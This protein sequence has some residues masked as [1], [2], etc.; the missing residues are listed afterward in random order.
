VSEQNLRG[1]KVLVVDAQ[2]EARRELVRELEGAG[3]IVAQSATMA[4]AMSR[5]EGFAYDGVVLDVRLPDGDGLD[6]LDVARSRYPRIRCVVT[7]E[8]GSIHHAVRALKNGA[9]DYV[10]KPARPAQIV[11][12]LSGTPAPPMPEP[13]PAAAGESATPR[14][15]RRRPSLDRSPIVGHSPAMRDLFRRLECVAPLHSSVL[16]QGETGTGKDL[17]AKT[18]HANSP[19]RGNAFVAFNAAAIP[20]GLAEAELFGH[21][22]GAFTG[23]VAG[24]IGRFEA[25]DGGTLFIDE[26][27]SM[28]LSLQAKLLRAL[29]EREV[30]RIGTSRPIRI[31]TRVIA[32]S[33]VDLA[34]LVKDGSFRKD[35]YYRLNVVHIAVPPLRDRAEDIAL[36]AQHFV[37]E[38]CRFNDLP[39]KTI[40]Q[41]A[42]RVLMDFDWPG[43]VRHLQNAIEHAVALS[44]GATELLPEMLPDDVRAGEAIEDPTV[45]DLSPETPDEGINFVSV[46]SN[47]ERQLILRYLR[48]AEGNKR[49]A[50]RLLNLSRTTLIDKLNRLGVTDIAEARKARQAR[51]GAA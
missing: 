27:S 23:A 11:A 38:S 12:A 2:G 3:L 50:A 22:K 32:A 34:D 18:I 28:P 1:L 43:N 16:I 48:K 13:V 35:L 39:M 9:A 7:A 30:E 14:P 46:M 24:R 10:I 49:R 33:N 36:L 5:L 40:G 25:A 21:V 45:G 26:V 6:V 44:N 15:P 17:I 42:L 41:A 31:N 19:R 8:F 51:I 4:D 37:T 47:L 20:D 29:Q